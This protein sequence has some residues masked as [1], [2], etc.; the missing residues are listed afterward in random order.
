MNGRKRIVRKQ[1]FRLQSEMRKEKSEQE[2]ASQEW[3]V[4]NRKRNCGTK[5]GDAHTVQ[6]YVYKEYV[7]RVKVFYTH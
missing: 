3:E 6:L 4:R 7:H 1:N 5:N 2:K